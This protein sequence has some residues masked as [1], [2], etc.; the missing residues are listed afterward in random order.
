MRLPPFRKHDIQ[1]RRPQWQVAQN[2]RRRFQLLN[3]F[4]K[5]FSILAFPIAM[6]GVMA[7]IIIAAWFSIKASP[8]PDSTPAPAKPPSLAKNEIRALLKPLTLKQ[9]SNNHIETTADN[10][11]LWVETTLNKDLQQYLNKKLTAKTARYLALVALEP[12]TGRILAM[13][14]QNKTATGENPCTEL[15]FPAASIF[16]IVTA[17]AAIEVCGM[18]PTTEVTFNGASNTLYKSQLKERKNRFTNKTTLKQSFAKS[19]NPVFGK[20]GRNHLGKRTLEIYANAF[21]F[22]RNI[23]FE[24]P[25]VPSTINIDD[26]PYHWAEIASGF[27]HSTVISPLH[28]ALI[29]AAIINN[30]KM[31]MPMI[32]D[33]ITNSEGMVLYRGQPQELS[34]AIN[35]QTAHEL[36]VLMAATI[37]SGT[38][39][40]IF[41][42]YRKDPVLSQLNIGGKTGS[43]YDQ[44]HELKFDWFVGFAEEKNRGKQLALSVLVAHDKYLGKRAGDYA[45]MAITHYFNKHFAK[46][47]QITHNQNS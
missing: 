10:R 46:M 14:S 25:L 34:I 33:Q 30:G 11:Q 28:G 41:R 18:N 20:I 13:A 35:T 36:K 1:S 43:I 39:R 2:R 7:V 22:N 17:A 37:R 26:E 5:R 16:K 21:G 19:V 3:S 42:G 47:K 45:R 15:Q 6:L 12:S 31:Q 44:S 40:K 23:Q 27:N 32:I 29:T 4:A 24:L 8:S 38:C 9:L